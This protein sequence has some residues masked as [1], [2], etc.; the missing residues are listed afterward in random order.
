MDFSYLLYV[1]PGLLL[2]MWA[3][4]KVQSTFSKYNKIGTQQN[5]TGVQA[6]RYILDAN[7]LQNVALEKVAGNL[8]DHFDP[9]GNVI[10]LSDATYAQPSVG[11]VGVAAH[12]CGHAV[13]Y[14]QSYWPIKLRNA[15]VPVCNIGSSLSMPMIL[16]GLLLGWL[17]LAYIGIALFS[18]VVLFQLLTLPVEFNASKRALQTLEGS[19]MMNAEELA[20]A[21]KV[22]SA[23]ALTYVAAMLTSFLQLI[24]FVNIVNRRRGSR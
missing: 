14:A 16:I 7:G 20:G 10:R 18:L 15:I 12:E 9:K 11:A 21:R 22:L 13:Q 5:L 3:Q 1:L 19:N 6:A 23:A 2:S 17:N 8:T 4:F 24:Y